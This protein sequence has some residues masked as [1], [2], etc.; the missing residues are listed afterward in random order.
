MIDIDISNKF[1]FYSIWYTYFITISKII[2]S[3]IAIFKHAIEE[4]F[5]HRITYQKK[6]NNKL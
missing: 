3:I 5:S 1:N 4:P 2:K 6:I